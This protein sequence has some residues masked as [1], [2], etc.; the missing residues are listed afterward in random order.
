[1]YVNIHTCI[2]PMADLALSG[3]TTN[4]LENARNRTRDFAFGLLN[5][6]DHPDDL[7]PV[8]F[9]S[10]RRIRVQYAQNYYIS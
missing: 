9:G 3:T 4:R 7:T 1:M 5:K 10:P 2:Q 6:S 8:E